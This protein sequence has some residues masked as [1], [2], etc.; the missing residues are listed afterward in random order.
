MMLTAVATAM[1][2]AG[3]TAARHD[4]DFP[5]GFAG[6]SAALSFEQRA[7]MHEL[8]VK[9]RQAADSPRGPRLVLEV[10]PGTA[11]GVQQSRLYAIND[12]LA[13]FN[14]PGVARRPGRLFRLVAEHLPGGGLPAPG[15]T[16]R[17]VPAAGPASLLPAPPVAPPVAPPPS[18][19][20]MAKDG[21]VMPPPRAARPW[22][23]DRM[24][25]AE[26]DEF[27]TDVVRRWAKEVGL[28][29]QVVVDGDRDCLV[30][31]ELVFDGN[32]ERAVTLLTDSFA[33]ADPAPMVHFWDDGDRNFEIQLRIGR[34]P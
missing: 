31:V 33:T 13:E 2:A 4:E 24:W 10:P 29:K 14:E 18:G 22:E 6:E 26:P 17:I 34:A 23:Q 12:T 27:Y 11:D 5:I 21:G 15:E 3:D 25:K 32:L 19:G 20:E 9:V 28:E 8:I 1:P 16:A 7:A 30:R